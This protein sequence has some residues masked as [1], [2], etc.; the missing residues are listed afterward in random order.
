MARP[1]QHALCAAVLAYGPPRRWLTPNRHTAAIAFAGNQPRQRRPM[2]SKLFGW[3]HLLD[4][5]LD[6]LFDERRW[7]LDL[8]GQ[9]CL[10]TEECLALAAQD[11]V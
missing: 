5:L 2:F 4:A 10:G 9:D 6:D 3:T 1:R 7:G 8:P 11:G